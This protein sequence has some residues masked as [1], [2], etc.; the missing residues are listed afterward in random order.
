MEKGEATLTVT[1]IPDSGTGELVGISGG[2]EIDNEGGKHSY[3][4][5]TV[6]KTFGIPAPA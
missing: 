1:I 3:V 2:L 4:L 6:P 5:G